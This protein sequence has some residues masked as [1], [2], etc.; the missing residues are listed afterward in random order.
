MVQVVATRFSRL[1][2]RHVAAIAALDVAGIR[3]G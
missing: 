3:T 2:A 1:Q